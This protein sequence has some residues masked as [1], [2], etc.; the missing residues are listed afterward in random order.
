MRDRPSRETSGRVRYGIVSRCEPKR[1]F[2]ANFANKEAS[3]MRPSLPVSKVSLRPSSGTKFHSN[4]IIDPRWSHNRNR[5]R[6]DVTAEVHAR[7]KKVASDRAG[8]LA[9][10]GARARKKERSEG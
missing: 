6:P 3:R 8:G 9:G 4:Y 10:G 2:F 5:S 7:A 1:R